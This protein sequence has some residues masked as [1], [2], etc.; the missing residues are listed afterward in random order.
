MLVLYSYIY[1]Y[2]YSVHGQYGTW[3]V[4][5]AKNTSKDVGNFLFCNITHTRVLAR[6]TNTYDTHIDQ[7]YMGFLCL[8][9]PSDL[10]RSRPVCMRCFASH[11]AHVEMYVCIG[12]RKQGI[13]IISILLYILVCICAEIAVKMKKPLARIPDTHHHPSGKCVC[14][15]D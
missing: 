3:A 1:I 8:F 5:R 15:C 11:V 12:G 10:S 4:K 6:R 2:I 9:P 7:I 14:V 13:Y